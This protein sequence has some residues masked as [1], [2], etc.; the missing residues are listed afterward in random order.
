MTRASRPF[1]RQFLLNTASSG[2]AN[3]WAMAVALVSIPVLL[4]GLGAD[5]FGTW[6]L[7]QTFSATNGWFSL[8]DVGVV[9]ATVREV[10]RRASQADSQGVRRSVFASLRLCV[11]LGIIGGLALA[12]I[13][14]L[15]LPDLFRTPPDLVGEL[16]MATL[17]FAVQVVLDLAINSM[18]ASLEGVHRVDLSRAVDM[19]RR[20]LAVGA[21][22]GAALI[23][24]DLVAVAAAS[25][26]GTAAA[27]GIVALVLRRQLPRFLVKPRRADY[28]GLLGY[29]RSVALLRPLGV[30]GRTMD[31]L[32][33]GALI[34]PAQVVLV[35]IA[36][37]L[38]AAADAVLSASSYA[39][40][41]ASSWLNER[42]DRSTLAELAERG[43]RYSLLVTVPVVVAIACLAGPGIELWLGPEYAPAA[44]LTAVAVLNV[45]F[46]APLAVGSQMLLGAGGAPSILR[47]AAISVATNFV[48]SL[49]LV[50]AVG[51]VGVFQATLVGTA[52]L[53]P[54]LGRAFCR[55]V[56]LRPRA[57][58]R[59]AVL[60]VLPPVLAQAAVMVAILAM[61]LGAA[62]TLVLGAV[63][64]L[65]LYG[66]V[67]LRWT[68]RPGELRDLLA[69]LR[70]QGGA[71][72]E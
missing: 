58:I 65:A 66:L 47:A 19:A 32:I 14:P 70:R 71:S 9:V 40:V 17:P 51:V 72:A 8:A 24:G 36:T 50:E 5:A 38:Q 45:A 35:E 11:A 28:S 63:C 10:A 39:V 44:G 15:V 56:G 20:G 33:V 4:A 27:A 61:P 26:V 30:M 6:V 3:A 25:M 7:L 12:V 29:G 69:P 55:F 53:T 41:P 31:R 52:V 2:V 43:T 37:Q 34:G 16:R 68:L 64:G 46:V 59:S 18:E 60:P 23:T 67:A 49:I 62:P 13:G 1:R 21:A 42:G 54:L 22:A 48:V 57:F